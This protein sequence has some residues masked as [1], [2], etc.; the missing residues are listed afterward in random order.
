M[1]AAATLEA[2]DLERIPPQDVGAEQ[3]ALGGVLL[4]PEAV[5][6]V[7]EILASGDFYR[8]EHRV[9]FDA[10]CG[11]YGRGEPVDAVTAADELT[12]RG[13]I[14]RV[15]GAPYLHTLIAAVPTAANAGYYARI[16]R[17][18]AVLRGLVQAG[19]RV[20]QLGYTG[21][22]GDGGGGEVDELVDRAQAEV[23]AVTERRAGEDF[24]SLGEV[25]PAALDEIEDSPRAGE[26]ELIVAK[27]C[28]GSTGVVTVAHQGAY[29]R[30][31]DPAPT[32]GE[33][34]SAL[35]RQASSTVT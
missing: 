30:F 24:A 23:H 10:I 11:L 8:P 17:G 4:S 22:G 16:V 28:N 20:V 3:C 6:D 1:T 13:E 33:E 15:G 9:V 21:A 25:M 7:V 14:A 26:A 29:T 34:G 12:R 32:D 35:A 27:H 18:R 2:G 5:A 31:V 19:T